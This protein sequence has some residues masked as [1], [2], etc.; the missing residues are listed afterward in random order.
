M[1]RGIKNIASTPGC[2]KKNWDVILFPQTVNSAIALTM[3]TLY[4]FI[5]DPLG[6]LL[7]TEC[8]NPSPKVLIVILEADYETVSISLA[9]FLAPKIL[10]YMQVYMVDHMPR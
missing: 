5:V 10:N 9:D 7:V 3:N 6:R 8:Q 4:F 1:Q 2:K